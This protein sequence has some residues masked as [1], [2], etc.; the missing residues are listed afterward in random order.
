MEPQAVVGLQAGV[1]P[2]AGVQ[3]RAG[4]GPREIQRNTG[5][6]RTSVRAIRG[7]AE[8]ESWLDVEHPLPS[9]EAIRKLRAGA[10]GK[11]VQDHPLLSCLEDFRQ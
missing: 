6:H 5:P 8:V 11:K 10:Q 1:G 9:K 3:P 4:I 2:Q 7:M